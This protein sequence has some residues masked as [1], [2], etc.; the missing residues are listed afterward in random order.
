MTIAEFQKKISSKNPLKED[1]T[2]FTVELDGL[3]SQLIPNIHIYRMWLP[4]MIQA[5][6]QE[7]TGK[8]PDSS[9]KSRREYKQFMKKHNVTVRKE[10]EL[11]RWYL[12]AGPDPENL[13]V[14]SILSI[15][16]P[17]D[18]NGSDTPGSN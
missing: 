6:Y 5:L 10:E 4:A 18:S 17:E 2:D 13:T 15:L 1:S 14:I 3:E 12:K 16:K 7:A 9:R 8:R 11:A